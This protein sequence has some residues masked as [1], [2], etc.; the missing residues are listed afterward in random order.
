M[1]SFASLIPALFGVSLLAGLIDAIAG[2][3]GLLT[4]PALALAG[5]DPLTA[6][7]TNKLQSS[8][9]SGSATLAFARAGHIDLGTVW[10]VALFSAVG[11]FAGALTLAH[12]PRETA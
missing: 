11:A 12:I 1:D 7:A 4:V 3:G 10:P 6:I 5:F 8:F 9:G 2:G